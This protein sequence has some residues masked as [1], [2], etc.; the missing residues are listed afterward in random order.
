M[1][2]RGIQKETELLLKGYHNVEA[3]TAAAGAR[4]VLESL[5]VVGGQFGL[6]TTTTQLRLPTPSMCGDRDKGLLLKK[7][8]RSW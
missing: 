6:N 1:Q 4:R 8:T 5:T 3:G 7:T 2:G